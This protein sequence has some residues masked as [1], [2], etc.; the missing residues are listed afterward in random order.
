MLSF[1]KKSWNYGWPIALC[2]ILVYLEMWHQMEI[3]AIDPF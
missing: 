3:A 1:E 2:V